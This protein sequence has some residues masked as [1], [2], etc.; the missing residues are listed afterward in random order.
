MG[1]GER[2]CGRWRGWRGGESV[3]KLCVGVSICV[4][5]SVCGVCVCAL[6]Y[7]YLYLCMQVSLPVM[8]ST[9]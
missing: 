5:V 7:V 9:A 1:I 6:M 8:F 4:G 2:V 3:S